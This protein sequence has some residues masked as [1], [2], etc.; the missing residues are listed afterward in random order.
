MLLFQV[1]RLVRGRKA[2]LYRTIDTASSVL[3][4]SSATDKPEEVNVMDSDQHQAVC[5][6]T[7]QT[8]E[9]DAAPFIECYVLSQQC[10]QLKKEK[11]DLESRIKLLE[12]EV[13]SERVQRN[14]LQNENA[15]NAESD[16]TPPLSTSDEYCKQFSVDS[17]KDDDKKF[18]FYTGLTFFQFMALWN[19]LGPACYNLTYWNKDSRKS[20][21]KMGRKLDP[22][23]ELFL[24]LI[25]L[26]L[27]LLIQD[28][29]YRFDISR[30]YLSTIVITW[31]QF[32]Y[33]QFKDI[34]SLTFP[35]RSAMKPFIPKSFRKLK[36]IRCIIDCTEI[37]IQESSD[38]AKRGN[39]YS[40]Y[41]GHTTIKVLVAIAPNGTIVFISDGFEGS[42]SD[43]EIVKKSGFLEYI[44]EGDLVLA[45]RGFLIKEELMSKKAFL[46]IPPF[47]NGRDHFTALEEAQTKQIAKLRIHVERAIERMKKYK[48]ISHTVPSNLAAIAS[49]MIYV[50]GMLVNFQEPLVK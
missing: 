44:H 9:S 17:V 7:T 15:I 6:A 43:K 27:G 18:R 1:K 11:K 40:S 23:N 4:S 30:G 33:V 48:I 3:S 14:I 16:D 49:Q 41:K 45:D 13:I 36:N 32:M 35:P 31:V 28:L 26:R 5:D 47:L 20:D 37:F 25:R 12:K 22:M 38:F 42:I 39:L 34:K 19:F 10:D 24:T 21:K 2:P 46:N 8:N 50:I 29:A